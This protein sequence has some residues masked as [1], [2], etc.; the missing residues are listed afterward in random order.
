MDDD[1]AGNRF[2]PV[3]RI[4]ARSPHQDEQEEQE[5]CR[6]QETAS[7]TSSNS[8]TD[9]Q[10]ASGLFHPSFEA[11]VSSLQSST[12]NDLLYYHRSLYSSTRTRNISSA[13]EEQQERAVD[14]SI[15][16]DLDK[17]LERILE[18]LENELE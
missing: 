7:S 11:D 3:T 14:N 2:L 10:Q 6:H 12:S 8:T 1:Y 18:I 4:I 16:E 13:A 9:N 15:A 5:E 17:I